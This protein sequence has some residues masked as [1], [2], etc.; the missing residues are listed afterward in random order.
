MSLKRR[1]RTT[2]TPSPEP[3]AETPG[4]QSFPEG[5]L[6]DPLP[7]E[8]ALPPPP[9]DLVEQVAEPYP[10]FRPPGSHTYACLDGSLLTVPVQVAATVSVW[11]A[12]RQVA[13]G[14]VYD[15]QVVVVSYPDGQ[16][17][18]FAL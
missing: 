3:P 7:P 9:E 18:R 15:D 2:T 8:A 14:R 17:A 6:P 13:A 16:K 5:V 10:G 1:G 11:L 4:A 12:G